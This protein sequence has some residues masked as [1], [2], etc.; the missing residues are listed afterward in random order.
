MADATA[1]RRAHAKG[2][3]L[4]DTLRDR[5]ASEISDNIGVIFNVFSARRATQTDPLWF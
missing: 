4:S 2:E 3:R 1:K 5:P